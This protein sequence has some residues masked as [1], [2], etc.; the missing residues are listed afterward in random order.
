LLHHYQHLLQWRRSQPALIHGDM[1]L[2]PKHEQV[3]AFV[4]SLGDKKMLCAFNLSE[5]PAT[6]ALPAG[7]PAAE[8]INGSGVRGASVQGA[9]MTFEPWGCIFCTVS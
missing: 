9:Q 4:R 3:L 7:L 2:L 1:S 6:F 8:P 5:R